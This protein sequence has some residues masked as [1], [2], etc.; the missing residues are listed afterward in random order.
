MA[1]RTASPAKTAAAADALAIVQARRA[2]GVA[3][4][5]LALDLS[6]TATGVAS[7]VGLFTTLKPP[8]GTVMARVVWHID[9]I[10]ATIAETSPDLVVM[11]DVPFGGGNFAAGPLAMLHGALRFNLLVGY[12][13]TYATITAASLKKYATGRGNAKKPDMRV[14]LYKRTGLDVAD[15]NQVDA[16]W[17]RLMALDAYGHPEVM[18]PALN[19]EALIKVDWP[20]LTLVEGAP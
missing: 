1:T 4:W 9:R 10:L 18:L 13:T 17:L 3:P 15:D 12:P 20:D 14:E 16:A 2:R 6:L 8:A 19:R 5:V 11:E 7:P